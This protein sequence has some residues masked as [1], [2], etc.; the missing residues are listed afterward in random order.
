[1]S[2]PFNQKIFQSA[3]MHIACTLRN[4]TE[5]RTCKLVELTTESSCSR[6]LDSHHRVDAASIAYHTTET[7]TLITGNPVNKIA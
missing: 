4:I 3:T 1:M 7:S 6:F 5:V 2:N